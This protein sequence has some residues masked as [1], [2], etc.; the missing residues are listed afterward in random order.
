VDAADESAATS[1]VLWLE[2]DWILAAVT[3]PFQP[4]PPWNRLLA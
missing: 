2:E 4:G 3:A 1:P